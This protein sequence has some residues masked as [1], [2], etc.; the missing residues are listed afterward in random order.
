MTQGMEHLYYKDGM[1]EL[2]A[3]EPGEEKAP[4]RPDTDLSVTKCEP[5]EGR[6]TDSTY[7]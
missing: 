5:Q 6:E 1:R 3:A 2:G 7:S 4:E